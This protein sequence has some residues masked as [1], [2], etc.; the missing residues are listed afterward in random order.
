[1]RKIKTEE[2]SLSLP[3]TRRRGVEVQGQA[4]LI[5]ELD[6]AEWSASRHGRFIIREIK[7][8]HPLNRALR[9]GGRVGLDA[10][11]E[12]QFLPL[13]GMKSGIVSAIA[14]LLCG[15]NYPGLQ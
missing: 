6:T 14:L 10:L 2:V 15:R 12:K 8:Q 5:S 1:M 7:L 13:Q 3:Q 9:D 11:Q 4:F